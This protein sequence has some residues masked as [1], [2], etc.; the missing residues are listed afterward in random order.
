[1]RRRH[2]QMNVL[3]AIHEMVYQVYGSVSYGPGIDHSVQ[4][5]LIYVL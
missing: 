2:Q 5:S 3:E 4:V 1:M